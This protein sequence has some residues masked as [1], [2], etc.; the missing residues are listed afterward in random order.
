MY[1]IDSLDD[2]RDNMLSN[3]SNVS[4]CQIY[5]IGRIFIIECIQYNTM[6]V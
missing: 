1:D 6:Y 2:R 5:N 4:L 3:Y